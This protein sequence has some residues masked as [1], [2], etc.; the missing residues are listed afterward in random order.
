MRVANVG[1]K[2]V[3]TDIGASRH[4]MSAFSVGD[5]VTVIEN[6]FGEGDCDYKV[7]HANGSYIGF[8]DKEAGG[9]RFVE[10]K[11]ADKLAQILAEIKRLTAEAE[12]VVAE[13]AKTTYSSKESVRERAILDRQAIESTIGDGKNNTGGNVSYN[14]Y[15]TYAEYHVNRKKGIVTALLKGKYS[16]RVRERGMA[17]CNPDDEFVEEIG[18]VIALRRACGLTIPTEYITLGG[19]A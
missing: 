19:K 13:A 3:L 18:K 14:K 11:P 12:A 5:V 9:Y 10:E 4:K 2:L 1:D 16:D 17:K 7:L 6:Q 15:T 8:L